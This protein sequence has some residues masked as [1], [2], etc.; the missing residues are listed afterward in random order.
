[1]SRRRKRGKGRTRKSKRGSLRRARRSPRLYRASGFVS[2][3]VQDIQKWK[4][5]ASRYEHVY[6]LTFNTMKN[7]VMEVCSYVLGRTLQYQH[8]YARRDLDLQKVLNKELITVHW[9]KILSMN[10]GA[11]ESLKKRFEDLFAKIIVASTLPIPVYF[12]DDSFPEHLVTYLAN[13][14][15]PPGW[16]HYKR[17]NT[18]YDLDHV[19]ANNTCQTW[20]IDFDGTITNYKNR[21]A[22]LRSLIERDNALTGARSAL[23][24]ARTL[25]DRLNVPSK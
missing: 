25:L 12:T 5:V 10:S 1:M 6:I 13:L 14:F 15:E 7:A 17:V 3:Y 16:L 24:E 2:T 19:V 21:D 23:M 20:C 4:D 8:V 18:P 22:Y 9:N 11:D